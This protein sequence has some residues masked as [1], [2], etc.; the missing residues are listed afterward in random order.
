MRVLSFSLVIIIIYLLPGIDSVFAENKNDLNVEY[1]ASN[2]LG[3]TRHLVK[4]EEYYRAYVELLRLKSYYP[5]YIEAEKI[6]VTELYLLYKGGQYSDIFKISSNSSDKYLKSITAIFKS[7]AHLEKSEYIKPA[8]LLKNNLQINSNKKF[9]IYIYKRM[10]LFYLL[11]RNIEEAR[12]I[13]S[14]IET[15]PAFNSDYDYSETLQYSIEQHHS[16]KEPW[17]ALGLGLVPGLGYMYSGKKE[18]GIIALIVISVLSAL[19]Y[20]SFKSDNK[21]ITVFT[22][23]A[24]GFFYAG[25]VVGGYMAAKKY[26]KSTLEGLKDYL[27]NHTSMEED[28]EHI[29]NNFGIGND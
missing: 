12:N 7:D 27:Y 25:S 16:F 29:Y 26:N 2:I 4:S 22:G 23:A 6:H 13:I 14:K 17:F 3:F 8:D 11:Q 21:Q 28:R 1:N 24:T 19:T 9:D 15:E 5:E 20:Y 18:N 10:F